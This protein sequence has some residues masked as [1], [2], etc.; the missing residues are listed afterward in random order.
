MNRIEKVC[1]YKVG[2]TLKIAYHEKLQKL[3]IYKV[4][5]VEHLHNDLWKSKTIY[6]MNTWKNTCCKYIQRRI[7]Q[8]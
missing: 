4:R 3:F 8:S 1:M 7:T 6:L 5:R 2:I